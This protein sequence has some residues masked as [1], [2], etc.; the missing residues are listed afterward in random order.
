MSYKLDSRKIPKLSYGCSQS[1]EMNCKIE[2][3]VGFGVI[4]EGNRFFTLKFM[5]RFS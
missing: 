1:E 4:V 3:G 2:T 5:K